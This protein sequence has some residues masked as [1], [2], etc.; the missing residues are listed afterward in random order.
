MIEFVEVMFRAVTGLKLNFPNLISLA[1]FFAAGYYFAST[2]KRLNP[3]KLI[4]VLFLGYIIA[5]VL[6]GLLGVYTLAVALGFLSNQ[7]LFL[8][9]VF[10]WAESVSEILIIWRHRTAF[11]EIQ[12]EEATGNRTFKQR[13]KPRRTASGPR[14]GHDGEQTSSDG[15]LSVEQALKSLELAATP[16]PTAKDINRAFRRLALKYH[17]DMPGGDARKMR[18]IVGAREVLLSVF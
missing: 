11:E 2:T 17:P 16:P 4:F 10:L 15:A 8:A 9:R 13:S 5:T 3:F 7:G 18:E 6:S 1:V 14:L 12:R